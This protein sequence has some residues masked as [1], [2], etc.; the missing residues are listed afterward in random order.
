[1]RDDTATVSEGLRRMRE[2]VPKALG[3]YRRSPAAAR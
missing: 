3:Q 1:M 2:D